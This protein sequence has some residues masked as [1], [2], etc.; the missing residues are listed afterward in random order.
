MAIL[1]TE[2][3]TKI[4]C[5]EPLHKAHKITPKI[6]FLLTT[7]YY[8]TEENNPLDTDV[9]KT[10]GSARPEMDYK[11][12]LSRNRRVPLMDALRLSRAYRLALSLSHIGSQKDV[13]QPRQPPRAFYIQLT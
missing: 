12:E 10:L 5:D 9:P 7:K 3:T 4:G 11:P 2:I 8:L 13:F 1:S 6:P